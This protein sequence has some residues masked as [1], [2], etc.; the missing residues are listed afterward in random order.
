MGGEPDGF[1][2]WP[3]F[4]S[5]IS[6]WRPRYS[7]R[8]VCWEL[9]A[10]GSWKLNTDGCLLGNPGV[11]DG[12]DVLRDLFGA[13]LFGFSVPFGELTCI[14][15]EGL[16]WTVGHCFR[17]ANQVADALAKAG[18]N[19]AGI[20]IYTSQAELP[21]LARGAL[22]LDRSQTPVIRKQAVRN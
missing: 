17:K 4:Y 6:K 16:E 10:Q 5:S 22:G 18:A 14:Q 2:S 12:G 21:R 8:M 20:V 3:A 7:H 19:S 1:R 13:L 15:A 9:P 11:S